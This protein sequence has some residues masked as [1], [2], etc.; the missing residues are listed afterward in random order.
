MAI[1]VS[2]GQETKI[3]KKPRRSI[4]K[5]RIVKGRPTRPGKSIALQY[6]HVLR[7]Q[8]RMLTSLPVRIAEMIARG[9]IGK[10]EAL[11]ELQVAENAGTQAAAATAEADALKFA[12]DAD[13]MNQ[14][15]IEKSLSRTLGIDVVK[16]LNTEGITDVFQKSVA[17]NVDLIK[18]IPSEY[19]AQVREAVDM[20]FAGRPLPEGRTL[21][22]Q[23]KE[24]GKVSEGRARTIARDQSSKINGAFNQARQ[25][26]VGI[27]RYIWRTAENQ[28]VVGTPGGLYPKATDPEVHGNHFIRNGKI[29]EWSNPPPDG[30]PGSAI[31]CQ[32]VAIPL[33]DKDTLEVI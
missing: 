23:V 16:V 28:K 18:T 12:D 1:V 31:N 7:N 30:H 10:E 29:F 22:Q 2:P 19:F 15:R 13:R 33:V 26:S 17:E 14:K 21:L 32:C 25:E 20:S 4:K 3:K 5:K 27:K 9:E 24:I 8:A 11:F 6:E